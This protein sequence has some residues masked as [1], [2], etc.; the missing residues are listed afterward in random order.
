MAALKIGILGQASPAALSEKTIYSVPTQNWTSGLIAV[1]RTIVVCNRQ[2]S[3]GTFKIKI[4]PLGSDVGDYQYICYDTPI[5]ANDTITLSLG[6][7]INQGDSVVVENSSGS[8]GFTVSG[9]EE[10]PGK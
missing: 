10:I 2:N 3:Q 1:L 9:Y 7:I 4:I 6:V 8:I 5:K